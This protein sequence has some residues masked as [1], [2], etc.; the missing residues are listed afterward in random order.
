MFFK[1]IHIVEW[2]N[3]MLSNYVIIR[4]CSL[5]VRDSILFELGFTVQPRRIC[6]IIA[7]CTSLHRIVKEN[8]TPTN[9]GAYQPQRSLTSSWSLKVKLRFLATK[10]L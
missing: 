1:E 7:V 9:Y 8:S 10:Y 3:L 6:H 4:N 5:A 2:A